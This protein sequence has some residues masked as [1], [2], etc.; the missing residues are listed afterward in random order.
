MTKNTK[1]TVEE[2]TNDSEEKIVDFDD[3]VVKIIRL[4][5]G[6]DIVGMCWF[7]DNRDY[8]V[9][10]HPLVVNIVR[11]YDEETTS[12]N[13]IPWLPLEVSAESFV[14][15]K[16][17]N[18]VTSFFIKDRFLEQYFEVVDKIMNVM[19]ELDEDESDEDSSEDD[20]MNYKGTKH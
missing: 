9:I 11:D 10:G 4:N 8:M 20:D 15:I 3:A 17:N 18:I 5:N 13:L 12:F 1:K 19:K 14:E 16:L 7:F 6:I 2:T